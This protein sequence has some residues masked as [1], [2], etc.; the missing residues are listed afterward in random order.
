MGQQRGAVKGR[1][2]QK[3]AFREGFLARKGWAGQTQGS[4]CS[5]IIWWKVHAAKKVFSNVVPTQPRDWQEI[6]K[7]AFVC[8]QPISLRW[9]AN[10]EGYAYSFYMYYLQIYK[11]HIWAVSRFLQQAEQII[12]SQVCRQQPLQPPPIPNPA[13]IPIVL[14]RLHSKYCKPFLFCHPPTEVESWSKTTSSR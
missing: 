2:S 8:K 4:V 1:E 11:Q 12:V 6:P 7:V 9:A 13:K 3:G 5:W 14:S 10:L